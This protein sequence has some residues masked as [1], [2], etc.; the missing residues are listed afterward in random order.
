L[1]DKSPTI[2]AEQR[3]TVENVDPQ[4]LISRLAHA[5]FPNSDLARIQWTY[6]TTAIP[7]FQFQS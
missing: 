4:G 7:S 6:V 2:R 5:A 3:A 1:K